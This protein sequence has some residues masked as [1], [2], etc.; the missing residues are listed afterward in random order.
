M[1]KTDFIDLM[2]DN[3]KANTKVE[4]QRMLE[5]VLS[6]IV[7]AASNDES[8]VTFVGFGKFYA[9]KV[10]AREGTIPG[11]NKPYKTQ[12]RNKLAFKPGKDTDSI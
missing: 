11:S 1:T 10:P 9:K 2:V 4:A 6:T 12:A 3:G 7:G 5:A 8:G